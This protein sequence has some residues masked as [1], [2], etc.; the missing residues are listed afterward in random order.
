MEEVHEKEWAAKEC[1]R[2]RAVTMRIAVIVRSA[3]SEFQ[4]GDEEEVKEQKALEETV[5]AAVDYNAEI[6]LGMPV[7]A[8]YG[9]LNYYYSGCV[10]Q[11]RI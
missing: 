3:G 4:D 8:R 2:N 11:V 6:K 9:G 10:Y 5:A 7:H 1:E